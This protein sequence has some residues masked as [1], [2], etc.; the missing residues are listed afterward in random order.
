MND[1]IIQ[2][3]ISRKIK[4]QAL[5]VSIYLLLLSLTM[6]VL[7]LTKSQYG[8]YFFVG[9]IGIIISVSLILSVTISQP[10]PLIILNNELFSLDFPLQRLNTVI[11]W[12][13]VTHMGIGLSSIT[14]NMDDQNVH[15]D[16][17]V[18]RYHDLK[19]L[20]SK[21]IEIAESRDIPYNNI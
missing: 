4:L 15:I 11:P 18:L 20:K 17:D 14:L 3:A 9:I 7:E 21:L 12:D 16:L 6:A 19:V 5:I 13:Q 1:L 8:I 2:Y 10:K